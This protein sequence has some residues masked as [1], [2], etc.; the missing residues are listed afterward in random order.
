MN[1]RGDMDMYEP[2]VDV[3]ADDLSDCR[4]FE[5]AVEYILQRLR[6]DIRENAGSYG[7]FSG[8]EYG[9]EIQDMLDQNKAEREADEE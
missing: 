3:E 9:K 5:D 2:S 4:T 6:Q 8:S 1:F 7:Y